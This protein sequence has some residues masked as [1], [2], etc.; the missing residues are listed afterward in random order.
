MTMIPS[1]A[2]DIPKLIA[3]LERQTEEVRDLFS[4]LSPEALSWR[5]SESTWSV[6]GH[7]AHLCI[8][9]EPYVPAM[10]AAL[11]KARRKGCLSDG[12]YKHGWFGRWFTRE[13]E[14][15][16]KRRMKTAPKMVPDPDLGGDDVLARFERV[17]GDLAQLAED[18][19]GV[20]LGKAR[21]SSPWM[22]L[23]RFSLGTGFSVLIAHNRRHLWLA[24]EVMDGEGFP[25]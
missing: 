3:E 20:D 16:P 13:M 9:N 2:S 23:M 25:G 10:H 11:V 14:P 12:P 17:Q 22:K 19:R 18:A 7:V 1:S 5:A 4:E 8:L 15:P 21:F 24:R 6:V